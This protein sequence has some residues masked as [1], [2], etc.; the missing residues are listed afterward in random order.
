M[1]KNNFNFDQTFNNLFALS[2]KQ[3]KDVDEH[4]LK[5]AVYGYIYKELLGLNLDDEN[6]EDFIRA[7]KQYNITEFCGENTL[8]KKAFDIKGEVNFDLENFCKLNV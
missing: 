5:V 4:F 6:N 2:K 3:F 8:I 7:R 1:D